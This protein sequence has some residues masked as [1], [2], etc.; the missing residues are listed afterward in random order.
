MT[1]RNTST[2]LL[3]SRWLAPGLLAAILAAALLLRIRFASL[4]E[5]PT[6]DGVNYLDQARQLLTTGRT[7]FSCFPPGWPLLIAAPLAFLDEGD[8]LQVFRAAQA[9]NVACGALLPLLAYLALK[10]SLGRWWSLAGSAILAFLPQNVILSKGDLSEMSFSCGLLGSWLLYRRRS[11]LSAGLLFGFTYLIRP[12]AV[13]AGAGLLLH[14]ALRER[15]IRWRMVV[16]LA[17]PILPYLVYV[18]VAGGAWGLS[19]KDVALSQ[20]LQAHPGWSYF[21]LIAANTAKLAPM[22]PGMLGLPLVILAIVG[23]AAGRGRWMWMLAP[24]LPVPFIINPMVVRFWQPYLPFLLL[25]AGLGAGWIVR[26]SGGRRWLGAAVATAA[27]GCLGIANR[28][29]A[30]WVRPNTEAYYGLRDAG[31][32]LRDRVDQETIIA[33]YKPYTSYWAGCRFIKIPD[34]ESADLIVSWARNHGAEYIIANV[35]VTHT[36]APGLDPLL[37]Q[38][39]PDRLARRLTL[40]KLFDYDIVNHNT[41]VYR[42]EVPIR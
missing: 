42:I 2:T 25:A 16:G 18:R 37:Q 39:L 7:S 40:V 19:S 31:L 20:S 13:L 22:L 41:A 8:P 4:N 1:D 32:W 9:A 14:E 38:P 24:F 10:P 3:D 23:L 17:V 5:W 15:R 36:L 21:G 11:W 27:L 6:V 34:E 28:D 35:L 26:R 33:A 30:R 12:E 29:D